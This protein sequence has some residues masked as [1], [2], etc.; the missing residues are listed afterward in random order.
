MWTCRDSTTSVSVVNV[1]LDLY[2]LI[3]DQYII[4]MEN[5]AKTCWC[6]QVEVP[7]NDLALL[8]QGL[9]IPCCRSCWSEISP[10][11]Q[12]IIG[13]K[14]RDGPVISG[15]MDALKDMIRRHMDEEEMPAWMRN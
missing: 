11:Q 15:A 12:L 7:Q 5:P 10:A 9:W 14:F 8:D 3:Q 13:Q 2:S 4:H 6:C 1:D